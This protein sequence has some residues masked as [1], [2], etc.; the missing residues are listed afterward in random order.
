VT[1]LAT[2]ELSLTYLSVVIAT[3]LIALVDDCIKR[4]FHARSTRGV[5]IPVPRFRVDMEYI[6]TKHSDNDYT[7]RP[8]TRDATTTRRPSLF[9]KGSH[10]G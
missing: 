3:G 8:S 1:L 5:V 4:K 7:S 9:R 6:S 10:G 2:L